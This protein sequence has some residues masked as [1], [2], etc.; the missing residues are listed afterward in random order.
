MNGRLQ[1]KWKK[2]STGTA[3]FELITQMLVSDLLSITPKQ[4]NKITSTI[5]TVS[6]AGW[7]QPRL[8]YHL[9]KVSTVIWSWHNLQNLTN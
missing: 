8:L 2:K 5:I 9:Q 7:I 6:L 1:K 3:A 4:N